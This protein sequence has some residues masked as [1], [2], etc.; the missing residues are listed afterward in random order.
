MAEQIRIVFIIS[1]YPDPFGEQVH[2]VSHL[3]WIAEWIV[4]KA[5]DHWLTE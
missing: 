3:S 1:T 4:G 5:E 2:S